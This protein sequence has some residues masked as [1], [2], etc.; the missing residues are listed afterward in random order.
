MKCKGKCQM[1]RKMAEQEKKK[2]HC[3]NVKRKPMIL[4]G[5][6]PEYFRKK[7]HSFLNPGILTTGLQIF[8]R[9]SLHAASALFFIHPVP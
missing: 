9:S 2:N 3:H 4:Y 5:L 1:M 6:L 8:P 7:V